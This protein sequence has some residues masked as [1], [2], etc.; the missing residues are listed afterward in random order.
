VLDLVDAPERLPMD[1]TSFAPLLE[2]VS[3]PDRVV[4]SEYHVEKVRAPCFMARRGRWKYVLVHGHDEQLFDLVAD[5][6]EADNAVERERAV[7]DE[8][9]AVVLDQFDPEAIAGAGAESVRRRELVARATAL[10]PTRWDYAPVFDA[11]T[12]YVR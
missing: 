10:T 8:L 7:A 4:L 1:G 3:Q 5:P 6:G 11:T 12:Q 9:R 2:G